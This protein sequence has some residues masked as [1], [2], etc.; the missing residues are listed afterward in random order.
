MDLI[1]DITRLAA[2]AVLTAVTLT[3]SADDTY[4]NLPF[5]MP[6]VATPS[7]PNYTVSLTDFG[8][9]GDGKTLNTEAFAKAIDHLSKHGGGRLTVPTG[10]WYTGPILLKSHIELHL[11]N[12]ALV[13]FSSQRSDYPLVD[14]YYEGV[15]SQR[16]MSPLSAFD[17]EDVAITGHGI[18]NGNGQHWRPVKKGKMTEGQW[19]ELCKTGALNEKET[20]WYPNEIIRDVNEHSS[21]RLAQAI[22]ENT[23]EAW[24]AIHDYLRPTLLSFI[25]CKRVLLENATFENSPSWNIHP[26]MCSDVTIKNIT[27]RNP[28]YAQNGDGLDIESCKGVVV[29]G[30]SLDVGDDAIC[31][32]SG[33]DKEGRDRGMPTENV[34]ISDCHVY[35]GH[36]GF[37][38]G[39]EMSGGARNIMVRRCQFIGTDTGLRFKSARGRGG[40]VEKI[41][42]DNVTMASIAK[43]AITLDL[44]YSINANGKAIDKADETTPI[45]RD[46]NINNVACRGADRA[47]VFNGLPEMPVKDISISNST[48]TT[49]QGATIDHID[50]LTLNRVVF[51]Q[52]QGE[53]ITKGGNVGK[54]T[55]K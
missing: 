9:K 11:E 4:D 22:K 34:I 19:K 41:Y 25:K 52:A 49:T 50:G 27:I 18:F 28:W 29:K 53:A 42:I 40:V 37:V 55:I 21:E 14:S 54:L 8:G 46:I 3:A 15:K 20:V 24:N 38:I 48:F 1:K 16:C 45:F 39:S 47:M 10:L 44:Y 2:A 43:E 31:I 5:S 7:I 23:N 51:E 26:L 12:G 33:R 36:G 32:K 35:H 6:Q 30:C 17:A 13:L